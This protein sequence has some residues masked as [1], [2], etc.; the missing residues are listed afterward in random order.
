MPHRRFL[1]TPADLTA[2]PSRRRWLLLAA[3][4][5]FATVALL[6]V[7]HQR[8]QTARRAESEA[9][10]FATVLRDSVQQVTVF[11]NTIPA[12]DLTRALRPVIAS[13]A[14]TS[15]QRIDS[16]ERILG[17][18]PRTARL[19]AQLLEIQ[20]GAA[21]GAGSNQF[22]A[23]LTAA[24]ADMARNADDIADSEHARATV[25]ARESM[26]GS[27]LVVLLAV[28]LVVLVLLRSQHL[29][30]AAGRRQ[31]DELR[32]L[33]DRD[34]LTGLANRRRLA[35]DV[36]QLT[37][38]ISV[39]A[40]AQVLICD[41]DGFK[42]FNDRLGHEAGDQLLV[43]LADRLRDAVGDH[44]TVYRLGGDEFCAFSKPGRDIADDVRRTLMGPEADPVRGSAGLALWP[45]EAPTA[46]AAMRLAD[47]RMY[48]VK[49]DPEGGWGTTSP[50]RSV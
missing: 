34:P 43:D 5:A 35:E 15:S 36:A 40:P 20:Q 49:D 42:A 17:H 16:L 1:P 31:A 39:R 18:D 21:S 28:G 8:E 7:L 32:Q 38:E 6:G 48:A 23:R 3:I 11:A 37:A 27:T 41:L 29:L 45:T 13:T 19:R 30:L 12:K 25:I 24:A 44:G 10:L 50:L 46:R 2:A 4:V 9:T 33:A 22:S 47:Q 26:I 14:A